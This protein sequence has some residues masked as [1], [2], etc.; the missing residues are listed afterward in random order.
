VD[1]YTGTR[2]AA[3][4]LMSADTSRDRLRLTADD[5]TITA[6]GSDATRVT[7]RATDTYGNH[8]PNMTGEVTLTLTGPAVLIGQ[9]P[10]AFGSYGGVGGAFI[11]SVPGET[12]QVTVT[13]RHAT[14]GSAS[15]QI[16]VTAAR[17]GKYL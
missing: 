2:L 17:S 10:F 3:V 15:V 6:D 14:L 11:R 7:I 12:G 1:G 5:T 13:A 16:T 8:R 9:N 4:L